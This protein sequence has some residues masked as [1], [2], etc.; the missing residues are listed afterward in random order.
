MFSEEWPLLMFTLLTQLAVG[1]YI[2]LV[3]IRSLNK[4]SMGPTKIG[5]L[6]VGPVMGIAIILSIFHLGT[7]LGAYRA[8]LN[9]GSSWLSRE[10]L[11]AGLFFGLWLVGYILERMGKWSQVLGWINSIVGIGT[12]F[13]MASIYGAS[14]LPAWTN[15]NTY[16]SFF[17]TTIV[18]GAIGT[19]FTILI[20]KE[21]T[22][23]QLNSILK[24]T[25]LIGLLA[26][27]FQLIY[28]PV[29]TSGLSVS[30][31]AGYESAQLVAGSYLYPTII[32][33][34]FTIAGVSILMF[35]LF[36]KTQRTAVYRLSYVAFGLVIVGEFLGRY[37]FYAT[38]VPII[39]G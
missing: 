10:I 36:Q 14:I 24:I 4:T 5:M 13:S 11:F 35:G 8:L 6:L 15:V 22:S 3:V 28:L 7:P 23:P 29:Y 30:G 32:R 39:V 25:S 9:L 21:E 33:W 1:S 31:S 37:I 34:V 18:F 27:A 26:I 12:V 19:A 20:S 38:G 16:L 17:G 2:F